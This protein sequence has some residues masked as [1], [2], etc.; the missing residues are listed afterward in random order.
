MCLLIQFFHYF[1]CNFS[2]PLKNDLLNHVNLSFAFKMIAMKYKTFLSYILVYMEGGC[3]I[4]Y[5]MS[6]LGQSF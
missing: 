3:T 1:T 4:V 6:N 2:L 5:N